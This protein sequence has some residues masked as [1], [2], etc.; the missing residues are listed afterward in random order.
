[1]IVHKVCLHQHFMTDQKPANLIFYEFRNFWKEYSIA[2]PFIGA[3]SCGF[4]Y[5][6]IS[7]GRRY[8][9]RSSGKYLEVTRYMRYR[10]HSP[11][12]KYL[13]LPAIRLPGSLECLAS[14]FINA[15]LFSDSGDSHL[16]AMVNFA[17]RPWLPAAK[18]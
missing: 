5:L 10:N 17:I 9:L 13:Q 4:H 15:Q 6:L 8:H 7:S 1:M 2:Y 3:D 11:W 14:A 12:G 18:Q 16:H